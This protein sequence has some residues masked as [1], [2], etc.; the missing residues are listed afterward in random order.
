[1]RVRRFGVWTQKLMLPW[2]SK[3]PINKQLVFGGSSFIF[4]LQ[5]EL[6]KEVKVFTVLLK[7]YIEMDFFPTR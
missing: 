2:I 1:M 4:L 7:V 3:L 5:K 6:K